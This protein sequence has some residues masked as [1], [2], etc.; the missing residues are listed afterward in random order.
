MIYEYILRLRQSSIFSKLPDFLI[1]SLACL[2]YYV[3]L[4]VI[5]LIL[6]SIFF[7]CQNG[8]L[9]TIE[10]SGQSR[11][12]QLKMLLSSYF[13]FYTHIF[14]SI[15][16]TKLSADA[17]N[18]SG[19]FGI[20]LIFNFIG[21]SILPLSSRF[22][23]FQ[24][25]NDLFFIILLL[26][27]NIAGFSLSI[28]FTE[29]PES[30]YS[31]T[32]QS[33]LLL[34]SFL[35]LTIAFTTILVYLKTGNLMS[36]IY[37]QTRY[38][39]GFIP[40]WMLFNSPLHFVNGIGSYVFIIILTQIL[41]QRDR[42]IPVDLTNIFPLQ[43]KPLLALV[44]AA[45]KFG[46]L[47]IISL[48]WLILYT[49]A[50]LSPFNNVINLAITTGQLFWFLLKVIIFWMMTV[51]LNRNIPDLISEQILKL[52]YWYILPTQMVLLMLTV[53]IKFSS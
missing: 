17:K 5:F 29:E 52:G 42:P 27:V 26:L 9:K 38:F 8:S 2:G 10:K 50:F 21:F 37:A 20:I 47:I 23:G 6:F 22:F 12:W 1:Q 11:Y 32:Y 3:P 7:Y 48:I 46:F 40:R 51:I 53:M 24:T 44:Q 30:R 15:R 33:R 41:L 49:G 36:I 18:L 34:L 25:E 16:H 31:I 35:V 4:I 28:F 45:W 43:K 39:G 19:L 13:Q 14:S